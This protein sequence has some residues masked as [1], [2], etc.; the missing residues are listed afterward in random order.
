MSVKTI[1]DANLNGKKVLSRVD[2]NVPLKD[3]VVGDDTRIRAALPTIN[4]ILEAGASLVLMS[5]LGRPKGEKKAELSLAPVARRLAEPP[6]QGSE[7]GPG[8]HRVGSRV[9]GRFPEA[10]RGASSGERALV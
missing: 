5:H 1:A 9:H 2:F 3:G 10:R 4:A 6:E 7:N 8:R